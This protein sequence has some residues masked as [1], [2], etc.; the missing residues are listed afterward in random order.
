EALGLETTSPAAAVVPVI[1]GD[2]GEAVRAA[3][4]CA[5]HGV[6]VGCFR[7][8]SVPHGRACLRLTARASLGEAELTKVTRALTGV[9]ELIGPYAA[10]N[11]EATRQ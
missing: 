6:R 9:R 8:P 10:R 4:V 7:P 5:G 11:A 1:I 2:P 3:E